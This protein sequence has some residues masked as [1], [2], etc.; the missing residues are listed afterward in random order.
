MQTRSIRTLGIIIFFF[1]ILMGLLLSV[2][3]VWGDYEGLSYFYTGAGYPSFNGLNC[4]IL[5]TRSETGTVYASFDNSSDQEIEPYYEVTI[6][7][8]ASMRKF[9]GQ[10]A[11]PAHSSK[12]I[13]WTVDAKDIDLGFFVFIDMQVLPVAGFSTREDYCGIVMLDLAGP[14]GEQVFDL[15]LAASLLSIVI[16]F[17]LWE[18][19]ADRN[20]KAV[21][22]LP[23]AMKTL[24]I[25]LLLAMLTSFLGW[26]LAGVLFGVLTI[27]LLVINL[28]LVVEV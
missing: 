27:L 8:K 3:A 2:T 22:N 18:N 9:E 13:Q 14:T 5:M 23:R 11:V 10:F 7:G 15:T 24:G 28:R 25:M 19:A 20:I 16:G 26:W 1:G 21:G 4:P 6:S 12:S 17:G